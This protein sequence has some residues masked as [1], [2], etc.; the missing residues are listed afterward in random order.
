V[1]SAAFLAA[2]T[3]AGLWRLWGRKKATTPAPSGAPA[4]IVPL[5]SQVL[6]FAVAD[7]VVPRW[8]GHPSASEIDLVPRLER[9]VKGLPRREAFY[10]RNWPYLERDLRRRV[11]FEADRPDPVELAGL[12]E[13]WFAEF[14]SEMVPSAA[15]HM[16]EVLR[17]D[18]LM[19]YYTSPAGRGAVGYDGPVRRTHPRGEALA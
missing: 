13:E 2:A 4:G 10:R 18:V 12:L 17:R 7:A 14:R 8:G 6:F 11:R 5:R 3:A 15:A 1:A 16:F 19:V 9:R